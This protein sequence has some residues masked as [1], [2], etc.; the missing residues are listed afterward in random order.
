MIVEQ[1]KN[2]EIVNILNCRKCS[3]WKTRRQVVI[4]RGSIP[5]NLLLMG[6]APG[7]TEDLKGE[8][9]IGTSGR[10]LDRMM[11]DACL[12]G[13]GIPLVK[14]S[15]FMVNTILC[16]PTDKFAGPNR[17][18]KKEEVYACL[19]N[20]DFIIKQVNP[21]KI[22]LIGDVAYQYYKKEFPDAI[23]I[24]HPAALGK[25]G[26]TKA[27]NYMYNVR[28]IQDVFISLQPQYL[29]RKI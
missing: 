23:K 1:F 21:K 16:H 11:N 5:A 25:K 12:L 22:I 18:P 19:P 24:T 15:F 28:T 9:F 13:M 29:Q 17:E 7:R 20:I 4:G 2:L 3:L 6:E 8:A 14:P 10:L 26:G 27:P